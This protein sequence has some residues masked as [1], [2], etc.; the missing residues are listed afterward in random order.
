[1]K[2]PSLAFCLSFLLPGAG[3][4]YLGKW[5]WGFANLA[6][7]LVIGLIAALALSEEA[8]AE[9]ARVIA[10]AC[11]GGSAGL[12]MALAQQANQKEEGNSPSRRGGDNS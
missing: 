8:L 5:A 6:V 4:W 1:M 3:L 12:A 7:V 2:S 11:A 10:V 9:Y